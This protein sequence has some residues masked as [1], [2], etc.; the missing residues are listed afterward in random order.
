MIVWVFVV[1]IV[2]QS[3]TANLASL[4]TVQ[5]L[6]PAVN[7]LNDLLR[8]GEK[9]GHMRGA[10]VYDL[11]IGRGFDDSQLKPYEFM[12]E[13][14]EALSKGSE[15]GG[16]AAIV[17]ETPYVKLLVAKYCSNYTM[18]GQIGSIFK[19]DGLGFAFPK[20][21]P[22]LSDITQAILN[23]TDEEMLT[24]IEDK[25]IKKDSNC[26][27]VTG[28]HSDSALGLESF[29]G[30][31]L[32]TGIASMFA[33]ITFVTSFFYEHKHVLMAPNSGTSKWKRIRAMFK[34]FNEKK[35]KLSYIQNQS[36]FRQYCWGS[37]L[38]F[39]P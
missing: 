26:K 7:D 36:T 4:L 1:L 12:E 22:L 8:N 34:I 32:I 37:M 19:T 18:I 30:L 11:L 21:S 5:Q 15:K 33:L 9:V 13:I 3:Y 28:Y 24:K 31:F 29:S 38:G 17:H 23:M 6:Q 10:Y 25:W 27:I 14:D 20:H 39:Y 2:T 35:T 16:I